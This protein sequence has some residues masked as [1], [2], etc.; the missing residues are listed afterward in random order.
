MSIKQKAFTLAEIL[1]TLTVMGLISALTIPS[2]V[3]TTKDSQLKSAWK[4]TYSI[5]NQATSR[6]ILN[7]GGT[8]LGICTDWDG[9]CMRDKYLNHLLSI[10]SCS[11][12]DAVGNCW[13]N[14]TKYMDNSNFA[15]NGS[16]VI[17]L[18]NGSSL[19][20]AFYYGNCTNTDW[21]NI[22]VCGA[23]NLDVNGLKG[24]NIMGKD[25]YGI[26]IVKDGIKP[27]GVQGDGYENT[28]TTSSLGIACATKYLMQ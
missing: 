25:I 12:S 27:Y 7:N 28:C 22:P 4:E 17:I 18:N 13:P 1:I 21:Q 11:S 16:P 19:A 14:N 26:W 24:P 23:L 2:L 20:F 15:Y 3:Q 8:M 10:K 5:I 6:V 9:N